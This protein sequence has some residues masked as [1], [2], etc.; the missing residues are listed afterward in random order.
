MHRFGIPNCVIIDLG[1]PFTAIEFKNWTQDCAIDIDYVSVAQPEA[2][3][4]VERANG[5]ILTGLKPRLYEKL[6]DYGSKWIEELSKVVWG[7]ALK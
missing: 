4:Q 5:L 7:Y 1:S 3:G 6:E 2:N